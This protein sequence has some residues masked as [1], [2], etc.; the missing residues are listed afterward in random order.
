MRVLA[1]VAAVPLFFASGMLTPAFA[2]TTPTWDDVLAARGNVAAT[3]KLVASLQSELASLQ[4]TAATR[5]NEAVNASLA[6]QQAKSALSDITSRVDTLAT[7]LQSAK[8]KTNATAH[9]TSVVASG[10]YM[11]SS[12]VSGT[13]ELF[14]QTDPDSFLSK[15][16]SL[17]R[18]SSRNSQI[19][20]RV[21]QTSNSIASLT[22]QATA[23]QQQQ[24]DLTQKAE[25]ASTAAA[26]TLAS[27]TSAVAAVQQQQADLVNKLA[28]LK[29]TSAAI[30][31]SYMTAAAEKAAYEEQQRQAAA[32]AAAANNSS[33]GGSTG[34]SSGESGGST[35]GGGG[36]TVVPPVNPT[37]P[38]GIDNS[39]SG[40][41]AYAA[42]QVAARGWGADQNSCLVNLW[43]RE[44]GWRY[45]AM[46]SSSGAYG[47]PQS[48]PGGKMA[49]AGADWLSNSQTQINW[50]LGYITSRYSTPCGAWA[51][52]EATGWY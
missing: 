3:E 30:E 43:N 28:T 13:A 33:G 37:P 41:R 44:S 4:T 15:L 52:S 40:A 31:Q 14:A 1:I 22:E 18:V 6:D 46:N 32:A 29:G 42:G 16:A 9:D 35:S 47:I 25:A 10:L 24:Q 45:N 2:D 38:P 48:L 7:E 21:V 23:A 5:G 20:E 50:G 19:A 51:H 34:G 17:D 26:Q 39:P 36:G 27:A 11:S 49:S 8:E 12:S